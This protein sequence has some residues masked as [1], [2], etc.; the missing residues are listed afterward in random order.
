MLGLAYVPMGI[1]VI[2]GKILFM[3]I[4]FAI[5]TLMI[6]VFLYFA[7]TEHLALFIGP[8]GPITVLMWTIEI[9]LARIFMPLK[10]GNT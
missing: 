1:G 6:L 9:L 7:I 5:N 10:Y 8:L 4:V 2:E 3:R